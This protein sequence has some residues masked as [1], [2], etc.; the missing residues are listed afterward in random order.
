M[1]LSFASAICA[2]LFS[3]A[4]LAAPVQYTTQQVE[5]NAQPTSDYLGTIDVA[6]PVTVLE[7]RGAKVKVRVSGWSLVEYPSQI[8]SDAGVRIE[9]AGFDEE[10]AVKFTA[11][12]ERRTVQENEWVKSTAE[13]WID[14]KALTKNVQA[15]WKQGEARLGEACSSCHG[16]PKADHFTANQWASQLPLKGGRAGH[17][18][19]GANALMFKYLQTHAKK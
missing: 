6:T 5:I 16:A 12:S 13:G 2:A 17:S 3:G 7:K 4:V 11:K 10:K 15:L 19:A 1:K 14:A 18:R 8:F 9:Y